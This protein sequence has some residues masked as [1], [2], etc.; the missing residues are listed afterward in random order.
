MTFRDTGDDP[1]GEGR[2]G[3]PYN[4]FSVE[5]LGSNGR[6]GYLRQRAISKFVPKDVVLRKPPR[7]SKNDDRSILL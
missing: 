5:T 2:N 1:R 4:G 3:N 6:R 7:P